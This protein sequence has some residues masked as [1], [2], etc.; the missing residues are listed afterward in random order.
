MSKVYDRIVLLSCGFQEDIYLT[1]RALGDF[2]PVEERRPGVYQRRNTAYVLGP[3]EH[4]QPAGT[5]YQCTLVTDRQVETAKLQGIEPL[6]WV[7]PASKLILHG[8]GYTD[9]DRMMTDGGCD[10]QLAHRSRWY[11]P[12]SWRPL[13][14]GQPAQCG[15]EGTK[16]DFISLE[17]FADIIHRSLPAAH[18]F[19]HAGQCLQV[20]LGTCLGGWSRFP[21]GEGTMAGRFLRALRARGIWAEVRARTTTLS[22]CA[23]GDRQERMGISAFDTYLN[24]MSQL[25]A[26]W[27]FKSTQASAQY[28]QAA[29]KKVAAGATYNYTQMKKSLGKNLIF[30][31]N[32]DGSQM[33]IVDAHNQ[34]VSYTG[35]QYRIL[36]NKDAVIE[37][38]VY[39]AYHADRTISK[40]GEPSEQSMLLWTA[41]LVDVFPWTPEHIVE[42]LMQLKEKIRQGILR[43][44]IAWNNDWFF[45]RWQK[46]GVYYSVKNAYD[47]Y[48]EGKVTQNYAM[49]VIDYLCETLQ[50]GQVLPV[51]WFAKFGHW[52]SQ[53]YY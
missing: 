47:Y 45:T 24:W 13:G 36:Q 40:A 19:T 42:R 22:V 4:A 37:G 10:H 28:V 48:A 39:A 52:F 50:S 27:P 11:N 23:D 25:P 26:V 7:T 49:H 30:K 44:Q 15:F 53:R 21:H 46:T 33:L 18:P 1:R 41:E 29:F 20:T 8:H 32:G 38:L 9:W 34:A 12:L 43:G 17:D 35:D 31:W 3:D 51:N 16:I 14:G 6:K 5:V 2:Q